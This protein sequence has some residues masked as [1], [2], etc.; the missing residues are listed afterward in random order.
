MKKMANRMQAVPCVIMRGG[1]SKAVFVKE[2][3][4]ADIVKEKETFNSFILKLFGSPD[5]R[6]IDG[7]GG[8][9]LLT[10]KFTLVGKPT[11]DE[12]DIDY[13]FAQVGIAESSLNFSINCGNISAAVGAFAIEEGYVQAEEPITTVRIHNTN[14]NK[15]LISH[16]PVKNG[17]P[18]VYGSF[19]IH[20]VPG[21]GAKIEM[22]YVGTVG[23]RTGKLLP[24]GNEMDLL[25]V[26]E[27]EKEI[28][29]SIVDIANLCAFFD[30]HEVGCSGVE[31]PEQFSEEVMQKYRYIRKAVQVKLGLDP[32]S[33]VPFTI[34]VQK[35]KGYAAMNGTRIH[36]N[37]IDILGRMVGSTSL[38]PHQAFP[39][40]G[41]VCLSVASAIE[42]TVPYE[43]SEGRS[44][45]NNK[46]RIGHPSGV[47]DVGVKVKTHEGQV[48]VQEALFPRTARRVMEGKAYIKW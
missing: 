36:Q 42:G 22:D 35:S 38:K 13:T 5:P 41:S 15:I 44:A 48:Q 14:T 25:Y 19:F 16:V 1:T 26:P 11:V 27:L 3:D 40:T 32:H 10:S 20:G 37:D 33:F 7:L 6:Q 18:E 2:T 43:M 8:A 39:G 29:V 24:T 28:K 21:T 47:M 4:I 34:G 12:A 30:I 45:K 46:L 31:T 23:S 17:V 9:D